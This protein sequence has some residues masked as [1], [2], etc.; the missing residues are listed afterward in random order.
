MMRCAALGSMPRVQRVCRRHITQTAGCQ[1]IF[2]SSSGEREPTTYE[3]TMRT[4]NRQRREAAAARGELSAYDNARAKREA[5]EARKVGPDTR[6]LTRAQFEAQQTTSHEEAKN[7]RR[8]VA[9]LCSAVAAHIFAPLTWPVGTLQFYAAIA[10]Y[11]AVPVVFRR[12]GLFGCT[13]M[14]VPKYGYPWDHMTYAEY[15]AEK[16]EETRRNKSEQDSSSGSSSGGGGS[17]SSGGGGGSGGSGGSSSSSSSSSSWYHRLRLLL[18]GFI[19]RWTLGGVAAT[20][21]K[22]LAARL[23]AVP[24]LK[25]ISGLLVMFAG[26]FAA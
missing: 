4:I 6:M 17:S 25:A 9:P 7:L 1:F 21:I 22:V 12:G 19:S 23:A 14:F 15:S 5:R 18:F 24:G 3:I 16:Q 2:G 8:V 20:A 11:F 13:D 10:G 26:A